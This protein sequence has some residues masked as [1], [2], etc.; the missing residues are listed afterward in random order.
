MF[1]KTISKERYD[2]PECAIICANE[3][4]NILEASNDPAFGIEDLEDGYNL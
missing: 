2:V 1:D 4:M 3:Q